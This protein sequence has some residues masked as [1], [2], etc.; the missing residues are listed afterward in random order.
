MHLREMRQ[1]DKFNLAHTYSSF[2][3]RPPG[4]MAY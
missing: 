2:M 4:T 3:Q 1:Y